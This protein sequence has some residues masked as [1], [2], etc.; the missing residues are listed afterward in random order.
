M[1]SRD[2]DHSPVELL[3]KIKQA[4]RVWDDLSEEYGVDNPD[5][6]WRITLEATCDMLADGYWE[7]FNICKPK[8][9]RNPEEE[10]KK[11]DAVE[12]RWE[13]D[14]LVNQHYAEVPF[15]ERQLLALAHTLIRRGL[16]NED[17]LAR[18][19]EEVDQRLNSA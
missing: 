11:L 5:P 1:A 3:E 4:G 7:T 9:E 14:Q 13:E 12:R 8:E 2:L 16:I 17:E 18:H 10:S 6:P 15:P 19:M